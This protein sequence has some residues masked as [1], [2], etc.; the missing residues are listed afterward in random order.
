MLHVLLLAQQVEACLKEWQKD[1]ALLQSRHVAQHTVGCIDIRT[2]PPQN[3]VTGDKYIFPL[4]SYN[5][6]FYGHLRHKRAHFTPPQPGLPKIRPP[7]PPPP[8]PPPPPETLPLFETNPTIS[9]FVTELE[10][11]IT[12]RRP[13]FFFHV[14]RVQELFPPIRGFPDKGSFFHVFQ[15]LIFHVFFT[16]FYEIGARFLFFEMNPADN[17]LPIKLRYSTFSWAVLA[18]FFCHRCRS[19]AAAGYTSQCCVHQF[20][21]WCTLWMCDVGLVTV[22][23]LIERI[24]RLQTKLNQRAMKNGQKCFKFRKYFFY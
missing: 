13:T 17:L 4:K 2:L 20:A 11:G 18:K 9:I 10:Q 5:N 14:F 1:T 16:L 22:H 15:I 7:G 12:Q 19:D 8:P 24:V 23:C 21:A 6:L 3:G